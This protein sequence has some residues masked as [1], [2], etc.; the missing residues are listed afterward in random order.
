MHRVERPRIR[1]TAHAAAAAAAAAPPPPPHCAPPLPAPARERLLGRELAPSASASLLEEPA[2]PPAPQLGKDAMS[3]SALAGAAVRRGSR[4]GG[5]GSEGAAQSR[6]GLPAGKGGA[7]G[8]GAQGRAASSGA[9]M[10][11]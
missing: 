4:G 1:K 8:A 5:S 7:A 10:W 2:R 9:S 11:L 3:S 6:K